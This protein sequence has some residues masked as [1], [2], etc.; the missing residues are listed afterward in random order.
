MKKEVLRLGLAPD[1]AAWRHWLSEAFEQFST[2][3]AHGDDLVPMSVRKM[4]AKYHVCACSQTNPHLA[5]EISLRE[6]LELEKGYPP[7][8]CSCPTPRRIATIVVKVKSVITERLAML[9]A[10]KITPPYWYQCRLAALSKTKSPV[11]EKIN[12]IRPI[13]ILPNMQKLIEKATKMMLE[14]HCR[15][16][17]EVGDDQAGFAPGRSVLEHQALLMHR[18]KKISSVEELKD[19]TIAFIDL[20]SAYDNVRHDKLLDIINQ[21]L[22]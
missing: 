6:I 14:I 10:L 12:D 21:E 1:V 7:P 15:N 9:I 22:I 8:P 20:A 3:K 13:G 11:I 18:L 17:L 5:E 4:D 19:R 16:L 2:K